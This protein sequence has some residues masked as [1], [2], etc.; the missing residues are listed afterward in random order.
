MRAD[1]IGLFWQ[2][3]PREKSRTVRDP[4]QR[5]MPVIPETGWRTPT[6]FPNLTAAKVIA[7]D[8]ET[9]DP[10]LTTSGPGWG[11]GKGHLI[12]ASLAVE[13]GS[14]WYFPM[15]H[16]TNPEDNMD[17]EQ[18]KAF[19]RYTLSDNRPKVGANL[20]YDLGW[21]LEEGIPVGGRLYDVQFAEALLNSE[22]PDVS[23]EGL[24]R[25]HLGLGK[26]TSI[27]YDWLARWLGGPA[28][29]KQRARLYL[30]PPSLA[31]PYAQADAVLP[32]QVLG[33]QWPAMAAR[34]VLDLFDLECRLI[35]LLVAMRRK[36]VRVDVPGAEQLY[37]QLGTVATELEVRLRDLVGQ[38]VNCNAAESLK[39]AFG[40]LGLPIPTKVDPKTGATKTTFDA[41]AL[42]RLEHPLGQMVLEYRRTQKVRN[43][44]VKGYLIDKNVNG[45]VH[46]QFH[47]LRG[48][49]KGARS[50]RFSSSDPNLQ[51]IPVRTRIGKMVREAFVAS[52]GGRWRKFDYSQIE[53][54]L[55]AH[56]AVGPGAE[57][58]RQTYIDDP[59]VDYHELI[60]DMVR[61]LAGLA[62]DRRPVKNINF[63]LIY[64]MSQPKLTRDL[65]LTPDKGAQ[66]FE[67]YHAA[68][69]FIRETMGEA[70]RMVNQLGYVDTILGRRSDFTAWGPKQYDPSRP[71]LPD[72]SAA[73]E[74][75]GV[76]NV[77]RQHTHKALNRRL[78]G[79][80]ADVIKTAMVKAYEAGLF[81]DD[82][83]GMPGLTVHDE[84]DFDDTGDPDNPAWDEL[85]R[86]LEDP[87]P[88]L[89]RIPIRVDAGVGPNWGSI[90]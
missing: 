75:W 40:R 12:G 4:R 29:G 42:E 54:R 69:P 37:E 8:V 41:A 2:D 79:G 77:E 67:N 47:P 21:C 23:L 20:I 15:R 17:P 76:G 35:P 22:T 83:C 56:H 32:L 73:V 48:G 10:E 88:G 87:L 11:R 89:L 52:K 14:S 16:E 72:F 71:S 78:Q 34:R 39:S 43:T 45:R 33:R 30:S 7:F 6:E 70:A 61:R 28:T 1:A 38:P 55:L 26:E 3:L 25:K 36:G 59:D 74:K 90:E 86:V 9:Y 60:Q 58:L 68:A 46:C 64:G 85:V 66:L 50:G 63:G 84:L 44:F 53:Y 80:A 18:V 57:E 49:G 19:L 81:A 31:G 65:G 51:N 62:L 5:P 82:A 27:L 13:D 24:S